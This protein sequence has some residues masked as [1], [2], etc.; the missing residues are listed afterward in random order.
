MKDHHAKFLAI[1]LYVLE[2]VRCPLHSKL[3]IIVVREGNQGIL[4][5]RTKL[6]D[7]FIHLV[8]LGEFEKYNWYRT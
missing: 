5:L 1:I 2:Y 4:N 8:T 7:N 3:F 6:H